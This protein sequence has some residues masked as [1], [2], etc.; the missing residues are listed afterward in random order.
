MT[1]LQQL[2]DAATPGPSG[3]LPCPFCGH[4]PIC[5][6]ADPG[7]P[8]PGGYPTIA[9]GNEDEE[10]PCPVAR[11]DGKY[12]VTRECEVSKKSRVENYAETWQELAI[13]WN[14][15]AS[16]N[17]IR[18][19]LPIMAEVMTVLK[20]TSERPC[21]RIYG[22]YS[23]RHDPDCRKCKASAALTKLRTALELK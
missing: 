13:A 5:F 12:H 16:A 18:E 9:C 22:E 21:D 11:A 4:E 15:R 14:T 6:I 23:G 7:A 10:N 2:S 1:H 8:F 20:E 19:L 17:A 3:L